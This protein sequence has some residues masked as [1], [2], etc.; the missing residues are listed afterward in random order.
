MPMLSASC[1]S[2]R[3]FVCVKPGRKEIVVFIVASK[4]LYI[5]P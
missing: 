4:C 1:Y 3:V 2:S 5:A